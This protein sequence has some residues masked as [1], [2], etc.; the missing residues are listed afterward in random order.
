[1]LVVELRIK[2]TSEGLIRDHLFDRQT[3]E[4]TSSK[5]QTSHHA[6]LP[7]VPDGIGESTFRSRQLD[8]LNE[9]SR[10]RFDPGGRYKGYDY[11]RMAVMIPLER[12]ERPMTWQPQQRDVQDSHLSPLGPSAVP[13]VCHLRRSSSKPQI[14]LR[15]SR[16]T[17][18]LP[19]T[20]PQA[21]GPPRP[22]LFL[23][24]RGMWPSAP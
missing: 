19:P 8:C 6:R 9:R 7:E 4:I 10:C 11:M 23:A 14:T 12:L 21:P 3:P 15:L 2:E 22:N 1:M 17:H 16:L 5:V 18:G 13:N 20:G 24:G